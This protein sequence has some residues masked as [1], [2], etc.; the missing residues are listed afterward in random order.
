MKHGVSQERV[1]RNLEN[2]KGVQE[3]I[4]E[5]AGIAHQH[6]EK[7]FIYILNIFHTNSDKIFIFLF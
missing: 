3:C 6:L 1:I 7:V 2:D 5:V 4:F